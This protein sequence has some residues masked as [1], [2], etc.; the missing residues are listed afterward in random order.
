MIVTGFGPFGQVTLNPSGWL[1][2]RSGKPHRTVEVSFRAADALIEQLKMEPFQ[3]LLMLGV[4]GLE[5]KMRVEMFARNE[6]GRTLAVD[7]EDRAGYID[8]TMPALLGSS[9]WRRALDFP[10]APFWR[11]SFD[12]GNYLCN[13]LAFRALQAFPGKR[14][15]FLHVP[16]PSVVPCETQ[17]QWFHQIL[18]W[19]ERYK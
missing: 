6:I 16:D 4:A 5:P 13:Y 1:A 2:E 10:P 12:A 8:Q 17:L 7:G 11:L 14:I 9:L 19:I 18:D 15:G 3:G